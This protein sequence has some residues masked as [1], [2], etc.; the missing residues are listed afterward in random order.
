[1]KKTAFIFP[2]QGA[3]YVGMG[4]ELVEHCPEA[5]EVFSQ[6]SKALGYDMEAL[7]FAGPAE[8]LEKTEN[9]QPAILTVSIA[10][11]RIL[12]NHGCRPDL[13]AGLSLGEYAALVAADSIS[14]TEAVPLVR[15]RGRFMQEAVPM[16]Q[17]KMAAII[18]LT[19][20]Q[21]LDI[22][23]ESRT[24]G[25]V[26]PANF[27]SPGQIVIAGETKGV[28]YAVA[29]AQKL[30]AKRAILLPVSAPF[31][32]S[33]LEPA[34]VRL[35]EELKN[36][37]IKGPAIPVIANV[38]GDYVQTAEEIREALIQQV[39]H[40][41]YWEDT[42]ERMAADGVEAFVEVGPGKVLSGFVKRIVKDADI[43]NVEDMA[44]MH[45]LLDYWGEVC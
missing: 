40:S 38:S 10:A 23:R 14:F 5:A 16:G 3:Q 9:T 35:A 1:M 42:I 4:K 37:K 19:R 17:G 8:E 15:A 41:V 25:L 33:M 12:Q 24:A 21:V 11:L 34:G 39:S 20:E 2:G 44:S 18:G 45:K 32:C 26:E 36:V 28:E 6:A 13:V 30:G 7:C 29:L 43:Y 27:N 31:H 22:C